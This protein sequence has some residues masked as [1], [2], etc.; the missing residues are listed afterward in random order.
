MVDAGFPGWA[1]GG[2][3]AALCCLS[4]SWRRLGGAVLPDPCVAAPRRH[5]W[6][7]AGK[8]TP[9]FCGASLVRRR[10]VGKG[11]DGTLGRTLLAPGAATARW[12]ASCAA[13]AGEQRRLPEDLLLR[14]RAGRCSARTTA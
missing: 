9:E 3:L 2:S 6:A 5:A 12:W 4:A 8:M 14:W 13:A 10:R 1:R 7:R 11:G